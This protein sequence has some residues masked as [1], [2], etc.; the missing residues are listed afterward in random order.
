MAKIILYDWADK[1]EGIV[2]TCT[3]GVCK[4]DRCAHNTHDPYFEYFVTEIDDG[5]ILWTGKKG[6]SVVKT[7]LNRYFYTRYSSNGVYSPNM[8][9][10]ELTVDEDKRKPILPAVIWEI[11]TRRYGSD[12]HQVLR[13]LQKV[14]IIEEKQSDVSE[15]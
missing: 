10:R 5:E 14:V 15:S 1:H 3:W 13:K 2:S 7:P 6:E 8:M 11:L 4:S 9:T 12:R